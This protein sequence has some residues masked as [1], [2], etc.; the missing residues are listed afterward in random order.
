M[1]KKEHKDVLKHKILKAMKS[2]LLAYNREIR[3]DINHEKTKLV[4]TPSKMTEKELK[5][6]FKKNVSTK[7]NTTSYLHIREYKHK[8]NGF[9]KEYTFKKSKDKIKKHREKMKQKK[10]AKKNKPSKGPMTKK[11]KSKDDY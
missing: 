2:Y 11:W 7:K 3:K 8:E 5:S 9:E 6:Y 10:Q 1:E 4:K